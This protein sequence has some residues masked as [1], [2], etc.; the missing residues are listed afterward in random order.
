MCRPG[1]SLNL[2]P[3]PL[4]LSA[5]TDLKFAVPTKWVVNFLTAG[6]LVYFLATPILRFAARGEPH[7]PPLSYATEQLLYSMSSLRKSFSEEDNLKAI[8][9]RDN[10]HKV[11]EIAKYF[12]RSHSTISKFFKRLDS[13]ECIDDKPK[14]GRNR[15]F[16][17]RSERRL[18]RLYKT[19]R[20]ASANQLMG[21][22]NK[23]ND[24]P[25]S[26]ATTKNERVWSKEEDFKKVCYY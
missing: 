8:A 1:R 17:T 20:C 3:P 9:F 23:C 19:N 4:S 13:R 26:L 22:Y 16:T 24:S 15:I 18:K 2:P 14:C 21:L 10:K 11:L 5:R 7:P 12:G 25:I 6:E